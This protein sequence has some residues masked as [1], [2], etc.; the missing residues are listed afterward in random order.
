MPSP[1]EYKELMNKGFTEE[2]IAKKFG[3]LISTVKRAIKKFNE[4]EKNKVADNFEFDES[5]DQENTDPVLH[6][7]TVKCKLCGNEFEM[8]PAEQKFY[9]NKGYELPKRCPE[10]R[11]NRKKFETHVCV[12]C[13]AKFIIKNTEKEFF[14]SNGLHLPQRCPECR[15][16]KRQ[17]NKIANE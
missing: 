5:V 7:I 15:K 3:V 14:E 6:T 9:I 17:F 13:N 4:K 10:C 2:E 16:I 8:S 1:K 12:D 11:K